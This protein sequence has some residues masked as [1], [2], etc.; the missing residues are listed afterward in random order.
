MKPFIKLQ[1]LFR[2]NLRES[3]DH[4]T[5]AN[6]LRIYRQEI[7]EAEALLAQRRDALA[8]IIATRRELEAAI[9]QLQRRMGKREQQI[10]RLPESARSDQLLELTAR[11][12]A[13]L[14]TEH[15]ALKGRHIELC[16]QISRE[17][18]ALR[19]LLSE[20][21]EHR[22]EATL[23]ESRAPRRR[24]GNAPGQTVTGRL[25]T[26]RET[27]AAING[28]VADSDWLEA[29][30]AEVE[31]RL[32]ESPVDRHLASA[33]QDDAARKAAAVLQRLRRL[34]A[35]KRDP[36]GNSGAI[37]RGNNAGDDG[38]QNASVEDR[39]GVCFR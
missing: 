29:G 8:A 26:L 5:G 38:H 17:E 18:T 32:D 35:D 19:R 28:Q 33:G 12:I 2:A 3:I 22:R 20:I 15:E 10:Q 23:L 7:L 30:M 25:A 4:I 27:R 6:G 31:E 34:P 1:T 13:G 36:A 16:S 39:P 37:I 11:E 9:E 21:R 24:T 14:E